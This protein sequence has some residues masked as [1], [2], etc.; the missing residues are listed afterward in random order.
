MI[1]KV[2]LSFTKIGKDSYQ[3]SK[4]A[5]IENWKNLTSRPTTINNDNFFVCTGKVSGITIIDVDRKNNKDGFAEL[6]RVGVGIEM[7]DYKSI[8]AS[9]KTPSGMR[10]YVFKYDERLATGANV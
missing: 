1:G 10:H 9:I 2:N 6:K 3:K 5:F 8:C 4:P 7:K